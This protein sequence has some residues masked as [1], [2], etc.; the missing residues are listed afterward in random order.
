M[1]DVLSD[2]LGHLDLRSVRC[3]R[4]EASPPWS[5]RFTLR[6][7][8][9]FVAV[10]KGEVWLIADGEEPV[11]LGEGDTFFLASA[12][13]Y[14][15]ASDPALPPADGLAAFD[16]ESGGTA[17]FD[18]SDTVMIGGGFDVYGSPA[19]FLFEAVPRVIHIPAGEPS[20]HALRLSLSLMDSEL[21]SSGIG[22]EAATRRLADLLL[23]H[24]LR[25]Y[26][27]RTDTS[28]SAWLSGLSDPRIG[29]ALGLM[30]GEPGRYWTVAE[31][32]KA[33]GMSRSAFAEHFARKVGLPP[34][35][36][37]T[38]WR[39]E[40]ACTALR[41]GL[42]PMADIAQEAGYGSESAFGLAFKRRFGIS[43]GRFR[44]GLT[45]AR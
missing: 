40:R 31:L 43:P 30:H 15:V 17:R 6:T 18:G 38:R 33:V 25:A 11:H 28:R 20:A 42:R 16:W 35:G 2:V 29:R 41:T 22:Y 26:T 36:Y 37:L 7:T 1:I 34:L 23:I 14:V 45:P 13:K 4:L 44:K 32:A 8:L 5:L 10:M 24:A 21:A 19:D 9:K 3:T 39:L 12:A 27:A